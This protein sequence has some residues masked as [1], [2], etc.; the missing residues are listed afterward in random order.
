MDFAYRQELALF[1][2]SSAWLKANDVLDAG[3]GNGY[4]MKKLI[5]HF[6]DKK[7]YGVD[8]SSDLIENARKELILEKLI[9]TST[10]TTFR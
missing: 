7:M 5:D 6:P 2:Q 1:N 4:Y 9:F 8:I 10:E 3:C